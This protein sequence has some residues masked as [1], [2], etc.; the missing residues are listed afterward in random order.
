VDMAEEKTRNKKGD[1]AILVGVLLV[2]GLILGGFGLYRYGIGKKSQTWPEVTGKITY[3]RAESRRSNDRQ[4]Y[5]PSVKYTYTVEGKSFT[6]TRITA[7]DAYQKS[8][9]GATDILEEYPVGGEVSVHYDPGDPAVSVL[10]VGMPGNV[11]VLLAAGIGCFALAVL[12]AVSALRQRAP[13]DG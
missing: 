6:G 1:A 11:Y 3:S 13:Q 2:F 9:T 4:Q 8:L 7:S 12:I 5:M 10:E